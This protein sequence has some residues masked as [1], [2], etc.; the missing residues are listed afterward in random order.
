MRATLILIVG[1]ACT[2][3]AWSQIPTAPTPIGKAWT[4]RRPIAQYFLSQRQFVTKE[5]PSGYLNAEVNVTTDDG[6][7]AF[8]KLLLESADRWIAIL[9]DN[10][11]QGMIV[12]DL[13]GY[14]Q[15]S[16]VYVG[17]P[18]MLPV[19]APEM[20]AEADAFFK[21]FL[22]AGLRTGVTI[23]PNMIF[24]IEGDAA[25]AKWGKWG[26]NFQR[27]S[28]VVPELSSM[29]RSAQKRWG[30]TIFYMDSNAY[31]TDDSKDGFTPSR[32]ITATMLREL[33]RRHPDVLI[34]PEHPVPGS[35]EWTAQYRELRG[36]WKGTPET[37]RKQYP[38]A[39]SMLSFGGVKDGQIEENWD[40]LATSIANGDVAFIEGWYPSGGNRSVKY[41]YQQAR[42][43]STALPAGV[44]A[45]STSALLK[46]LDDPDPAVRFQVV[47]ALGTLEDTT[48]GEALLRLAP[49]EKDW[50]V[51]K[52]TVIALGKLKYAAALPWLKTLEKPENTKGFQLFA[53]KAVQQIRGT[54]QPPDPE[55]NLP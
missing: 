22:D 14:S 17:D 1:L 11:A 43:Q 7:A 44:D 34:I 9:K 6:T 51:K 32:L 52:E 50:L 28:T 55:N 26:Y 15:A 45:R 5:N 53:R 27:E 20:D 13:E 37:E 29:I 25:I 18:R 19:Y 49:N 54:D 35:H 33:R 4:D 23:R 42:Y 2:C 16:M 21:K 8:R 24:R 41:L 36:G 30:C 40:A 38:G 10:N 39:F 12:W 46:L 48:Q 3:V 47:R 31:T